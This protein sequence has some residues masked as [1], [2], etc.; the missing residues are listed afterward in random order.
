MQYAIC[1]MHVTSQDYDEV[2]Q[3][4]MQVSPASIQPDEMTGGRPK[5]EIA[6]LF[7]AALI[8]RTDVLQVPLLLMLFF[9]F[10]PSVECLITFMNFSFASSSERHKR[11]TS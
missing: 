9:S 10:F 4:Y 7:H 5:E 2:R 3:Q 8:G 6:V 1:T 11:H